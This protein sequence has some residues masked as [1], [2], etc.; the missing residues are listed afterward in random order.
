LPM[1]KTSFKQVH[2]AGRAG[3][4][5]L[6]AAAKLHPSSEQQALM[7]N[8]AVQHRPEVA[9]DRAHMNVSSQEDVV[10]DYRVLASK[11]PW[12]NFLNVEKEELRVLD[13]CSGTGRWAQ[14]F[15]EMVLKPRGI[16]NVT[17]DFADICARS[18]SV[19][20]DRLLHIQN[21]GSG[22]LFTGDLCELSHL[23]ASTL[24][25]NV[26]VNMHGLY[27]I[28]KAKLPMAVH[29][30]HDALAPGG[31][32]LIALGAEESAYQQ[33]PRELG[34][35]YC[36][37]NDVLEACSSLGIHYTSSNVTYY[38]E[39]KETDKE[40]LT[41]FLM[42][43]CGG[44]SFGVDDAVEKSSLEHNADKLADIV[45]HFASKNF[46]PDSR[47]YRFFQPVTVV[48][49]RRDPALLPEMQ[50]YGNYYAEAYTLRRESSTMQSN[51]EAWL[52]TQS[53]HH[54]RS[55]GL[56]GR[57]VMAGKS[58]QAID[59]MVSRP[60]RVLS[61]GCGGGELDLALIEGLADSFQ[62]WGYTGIEYIGVEPSVALRS[63]FAE[64]VLTMKNMPFLSSVSM[65]FV[66][67][68]FDPYDVRMD[69]E[70]DIVLLGHVLYYFENKG[71]ALHSAM[72]LTR[73][74]G[75]TLVIHQ[76]AE[77]IPELQVE[78]LPKL[79]S[80]MRDMFTAD[81]IQ[82]LLQGELSEQV[83][84]FQRHSVDAFLDISE[85]VQ[86]TDDGM[87][88][89]SFCL[90]ADHRT[91]SSEVAQRSADAF[92]R[93]ASAQAEPG[94]AGGPFLK[95]PVSCFV[96]SSRAADQI[97]DEGES[98]TRRVSVDTACMLKRGSSTWSLST[99]S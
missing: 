77:G 71:A 72:Q 48:E 79:R 53:K 13:A 84:G 87:K 51:M 54:L 43:E 42:D 83:E 92:K 26:I 74:G 85:I 19:L 41:R 68:T 32:M 2:V 30:M 46:D 59:V 81:D 8:E 27:G 36:T 89:M 65:E 99:W 22:S 5:R 61:I 4:Y 64:R 60:L 58:V 6:F 38:E 49:I 40:S 96:I 70:A 35:R 39:Y 67:M 14:A 11:L 93:L 31:T 88:I 75:K 9:N 66:D 18:M 56:E 63:E 34:W 57:N 24:S 25:Y 45:A 73:P 17:C 3:R 82:E 29:A 69:H 16:V 21:L 95:E 97:A 15:S 91:A 78:L 50:S 7:M 10:Q 20:N 76:D 80:T 1:L 44:N 37:P 12:D 98:L 28:P 62:N 94:R 47:T 55:L 33:F 52:K 23:G 86:G 90:E